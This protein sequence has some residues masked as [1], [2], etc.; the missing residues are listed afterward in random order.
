MVSHTHIGICTFKHI[1]LHYIIYAHK[2]TFKV[3]INFYLLP[4]IHTHIYVYFFQNTNILYSEWFYFSLTGCIAQHTVKDNATVE[5]QAAYHP[6][7]EAQATV[8]FKEPRGFS[9]PNFVSGNDLT[10]FFT[11]L[12]CDLY[13]WFCTVV[14]ISFK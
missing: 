10:E 5:N 7:N 14:P 12:F 13:L 2:H 9:M 1:H 8:D 6:T 11:W 3:W 4:Y